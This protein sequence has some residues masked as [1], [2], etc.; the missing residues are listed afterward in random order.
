MYKL[1][2]F[3]RP[4][5]F[6]LDP[7]TAHALALTG[8]IAPRA[9]ASRKPWRPRLPRIARHGDGHHVSESRRARRRTRQE[10]RAS[11]R[12]RDVRLRLSRGRHRDAARAAGESEAADVSPAADR[13]R[14]STGWASTTMASTRLVANVAQSRYRRRARH[15][16]R[17]ELRHA[18]RAR[19][20]RL[21][22]VP[23]RRVPAC[24]LRHDQHFVAEHARLAR[25]AGG[26]RAE[27]AACALEA[28]TGALA[29]SHGRY[30]P[31]A[32]KIAPDLDRRCGARD[33]TPARRA[34]DRWRDRHQHDD[35]ARRRDRRAARARKRAGCRAHRCANARRLS[36][37]RSR[38][39]WAARCRSSASAA[40]CSGDDAREKIA[41]GASLVQLYTGLIYRGPAL[42]AEC[43]EA[44]ASDR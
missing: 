42:V 15:Q 43:V 44:L 40:S 22:H 12:T 5:L 8:S 24:A 18:E 10:R 30:V 32:V 14:S 28:R 35:R 4:F 33:R 23:A 7:E 19:R 9:S 26:G 13:A 39:R 11:A 21:C 6:A 1:Y 31:L 41:A 20:R 29:Q 25:P 34:R 38:M 17:Q 36:Y 3:A 37:A 27:R 16:H 2:P